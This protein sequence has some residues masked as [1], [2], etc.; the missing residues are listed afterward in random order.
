MILSTTSAHA[1]YDYD[2]NPALRH[3]FIML[4]LYACAARAE[5]VEYYDPVHKSDAITYST[6][7][8]KRLDEMHYSISVFTNYQAIQTAEVNRQKIQ[9]Q[10]K[11]EMQFFGCES[12]D[13]ALGNY[14]LYRD[15]DALG[16]K[17]AVVQKDL[18]WNPIVAGSLQM[19][20]LKK[21]CRAR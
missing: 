8:I 20:L 16:P 14:E 4:A 10:S 15:R 21:F 18:T 7:S 17:T 13:F 5:W 11:T 9:Y 3:L 1:K 19:E 6:S 2:M 12:Q